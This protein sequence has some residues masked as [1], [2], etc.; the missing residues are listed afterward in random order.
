[1]ERCACALL[2]ASNLKLFIL[3]VYTTGTVTPVKLRL[4]MDG[5]CFERQGMKICQPWLMGRTSLP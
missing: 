2:I 4:R 3:L 1:M 5:S